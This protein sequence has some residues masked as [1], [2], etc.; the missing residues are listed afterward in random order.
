MYRLMQTLESQGKEVKFGIDPVAGRIP[1]HMNVLLTEAGVPY[2]R[3]DNL[4]DILKV[5][6]AEGS[7]SSSV[8]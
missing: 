3:L 8:A 5:E 1:G 4:E 6:N 7:S 2:E